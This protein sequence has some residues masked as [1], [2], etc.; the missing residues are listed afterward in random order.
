[1]TARQP[2]APAGRLC[3]FRHCSQQETHDTRWQPRKS[4]AGCDDATRRKRDGCPPDRTALRRTTALL[5]VDVATR[6]SSFE[7]GATIVGVVP[8]GPAA[9]AGLMAGD[10]IVSLGGHA[11]T[12]PNALT[13]ELMSQHPGANVTVQYLRAGRQQTATLVLGNG[14]PQ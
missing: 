12:T 4:G 11:I 5:G 14:P 10:T 7:S 3:L 8:G 1:M 6:R 2:A 13:A 9:T